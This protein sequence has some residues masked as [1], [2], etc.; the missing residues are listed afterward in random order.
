MQNVPHVMYWLKRFSHFVV[1][2]RCFLV[3]WKSIVQSLV[4]KLCPV[5]MTAVGL[6]EVVWLHVHRV[7]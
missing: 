2:L 3:I 7:K 4:G 1:M 5:D 6:V